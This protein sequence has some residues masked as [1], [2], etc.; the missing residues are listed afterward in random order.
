LDELANNVQHVWNVDPGT[1]WIPN[2]F[3]FDSDGDDLENDIYF[4]NRLI[5]HITK[6]YCVNTRRIFAVG[7]GTGGG[8]TRQL[9]CQPAV[10]RRIAAFA[11]VGGAFFKSDDPKDRFWGTCMIGRRPISVITIHGD[12]DNQWPASKD[13][14]SKT[15]AP[16]NALSAREYT[17]Q[18]QKLNLCGNPVNESRP[19]VTSNAVFLTQLE[20]GQKSESICYG[21]S[22]IKTTYRCGKPGRYSRPND[23][24]QVEEKDLGKLDVV[25]LEVVGFEHGWPRVTGS[26]G[27]REFHGKQVMPE[28][29]SAAAFDAT[30]TILNFFAHHKLPTEGVVHAQAKALL[31]ERGARIYDESIPGREPSMHEFY[32]RK[33]DEL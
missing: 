4:T 3:S 24:F 31:I 6:K 15:S 10:S 21:G 8:V 13:K 26:G 20:N 1:E 19:S 28:P 25:H 12:S 11:A 22:V 32:G 17:D 30:S 27:E 23:D 9:A 14:L 7:Q 16:K 29:G 33:R 2:E 18:W 5:D